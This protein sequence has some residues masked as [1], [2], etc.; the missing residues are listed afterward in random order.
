VGRHKAAPV[1]LA[2]LCYPITDA[3][4]RGNLS[5]FPETV[6]LVPRSVQSLSLVHPYKPER[7]H[8][9]DGSALRPAP[10]NRKDV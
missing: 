5:A 8:K 7:P 4:S 10:R 2:L 6:Y 9:R 1:T 3:R